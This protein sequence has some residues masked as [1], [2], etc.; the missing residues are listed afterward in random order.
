MDTNEHKIILWPQRK[1]RKIRHGFT[2]DL[3]GFKLGHRDFLDRI[4]G[5]FSHQQY[6]NYPTLLASRRYNLPVFA[7]FYCKYIAAFL[8]PI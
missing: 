3:H 7:R 1:K 5:V 8:M 2:Q 6:L 4:T